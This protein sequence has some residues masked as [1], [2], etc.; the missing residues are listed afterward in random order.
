MLPIICVFA[1]TED[2][3]DLRLFKCVWENQ[4]AGT[5]GFLGDYSR[6]GLMLTDRAPF[7]VEGERVDGLSRHVD[8]LNLPKDRWSLAEL[9]RPSL[10]PSLRTHFTRAGIEWRG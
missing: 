5:L 9:A 8:W 6:S 7:S 10:I 4:R 2:W 3:F 1:G